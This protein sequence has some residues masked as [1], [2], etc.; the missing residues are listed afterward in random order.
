MIFSY[1][2][3]LSFIVLQVHEV[4]GFTIKRIIGAP[5]RT[6]AYNHYILYATKIS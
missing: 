4:Y 3:A 5:Y 6:D 2:H 1:A